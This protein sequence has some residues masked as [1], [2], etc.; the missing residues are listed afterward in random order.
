MVVPQ[1]D[2]GDKTV[3]EVGDQTAIL[4]GTPRAAQTQSEKPR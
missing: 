2:D 3:I 1:D 4:A